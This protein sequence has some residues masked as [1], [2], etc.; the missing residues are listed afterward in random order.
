MSDC[1]VDPFKNHISETT[2]ETAFFSLIIPLQEKIPRVLLDLN[3]INQFGQLVRETNKTLESPLYQGINSKDGDVINIGLCFLAK[4]T[5]QRGDGFK[6]KMG[7]F[8]GP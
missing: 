8:L 6:W 5:L 4:I 7:Y 2:Y 3:I 1:R